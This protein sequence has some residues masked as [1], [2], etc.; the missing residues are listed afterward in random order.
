MMRS[1]YTEAGLSV[2]PHPNKRKQNSPTSVRSDLHRAPADE[3]LLSVTC[4]PAFVDHH[5]PSVQRQPPSV[6]R[7]LPPKAPGRPQQTKPRS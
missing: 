1:S 2:M 5:L 3:D 6:K 4:Q 7:F